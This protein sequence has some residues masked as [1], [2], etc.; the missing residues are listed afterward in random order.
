VEKRLIENLAIGWFAKKLENKWQR[1]RPSL[2]LKVKHTS[3]IFGIGVD[4]LSN[5]PHCTLY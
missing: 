2:K 1:P 3:L 4:D 5:C